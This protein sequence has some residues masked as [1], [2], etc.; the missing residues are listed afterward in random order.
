MYKPATIALT[1]IF[2]Y[3]HIQAFRRTKHKLGVLGNM[4]GWIIVPAL[5]LTGSCIFLPAPM[6]FWQHY[7]A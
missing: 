1:C 3:F 4:Q 2:F 6:I 5:H 7:V